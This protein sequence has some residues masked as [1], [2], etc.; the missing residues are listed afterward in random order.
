MTATAAMTSR[1][2]G[3]EPTTSR[4]TALSEQA[5]QQHGGQ[6]GAQQ[7]LGGVGDDG[8]GPELASGAALRPGQARA[9]R[10][11]TSAASAMPSGRGR[12]ASLAGG[13]RPSASRP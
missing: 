10:P 2:D 9:S 7:G 13:Q 4:A 5:H 1:G 3:V 8:A 11:A 12:L 6:V